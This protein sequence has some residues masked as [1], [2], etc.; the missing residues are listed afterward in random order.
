MVSLIGGY[1][2]LCTTEAGTL[3]DCVRRFSGI[4]SGSIMS[5]IVSEASGP[6]GSLTSGLKSACQEFCE[7]LPFK[8]RLPTDEEREQLNKDAVAR[9]SAK[10]P[11]YNVMVVLPE[12]EQDFQGC[13]SIDLTFCYGL[14]RQI[15]RIY[16][17][18]RGTFTL[19]GDGGFINWA[20][21]GKYERNDKTVTF[22]DRT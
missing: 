17:F 14:L 20:F 6:D 15:V 22:S 5:F 9:L 16:V 3:A 12:H 7:Q 11:K 4:S 19:R 1:F 2:T 10:Y 8:D 21:N 18:K 13:T